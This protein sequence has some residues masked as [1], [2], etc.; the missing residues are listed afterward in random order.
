MDVV[1]YPESHNEDPNETN[2]PEFYPTGSNDMTVV[3]NQKHPSSVLRIVNL[4]TWVPVG[5]S[6]LLGERFDGDA[7]NGIKGQVTSGLLKR[8]QRLTDEV[9]LFRAIKASLS[10]V[11]PSDELVEILESEFSEIH[12]EAVQKSLRQA[13]QVG[14]IRIKRLIGDLLLLS[15]DSSS[16]FRA[17]Q[18]SQLQH[19]RETGPWQKAGQCLFRP[20]SMNST[21]A[22]PCNRGEWPVRRAALRHWEVR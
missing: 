1:G 12:S 5:V 9:W 22:G 8:P 19:R 13:N 7:V 21:T 14:D 4:L 6:Q 15:H 2:V 3:L 18:I 17:Y 11:K 10:F 20:Q 16:S